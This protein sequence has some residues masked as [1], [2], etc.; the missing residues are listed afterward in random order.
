MKC[1]TDS[2]VIRLASVNHLYVVVRLH[3]NI[4]KAACQDILLD[5]QAFLLDTGDSA[6]DYGATEKGIRMG[7]YL[8]VAACCY[9]VTLA[10]ARR[11]RN[12]AFRASAA[13]LAQQYF[14]PLDFLIKCLPHTGHIAFR[15][16]G[17]TIFA[18]TG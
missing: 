8:M 15:A 1:E 6:T 7:G 12:C 5:S 13:H 14:T 10:I 17:L 9:I 11:S 4:W 3:C 2:F 16:L 18:P